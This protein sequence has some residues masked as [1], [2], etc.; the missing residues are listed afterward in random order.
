MTFLA[1]FSQEN[2]EFQVDQR[3]VTQTHAPGHKRR[4][5]LSSFYDPRPLN[6][7]RINKGVPFQKMNLNASDIVHVNSLIEIAA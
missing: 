5:V 7:V 6:I 1:L 4:G 3:G 2:G